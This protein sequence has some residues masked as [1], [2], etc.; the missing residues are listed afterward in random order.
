MSATHAKQKFRSIRFKLIAVAIV[1]EVVLLALVLANSSR[2]LQ[3]AMESEVGTRLHGLESRLNASLSARV[4]QHDHA[5]IAA[6]LEEL[7]RPNQ[8]DIAYIVVINNQ[9]EV[10]AKAGKVDPAHLPPLDTTVA[11]AMS[12]DIYDVDIPLTLQGQSLGRARLGISLESM[13]KTRDDLM[14]Q[15][16]VIS[17]A[18]VA[19]SLLL[20]TAGGIALTRHIPLLLAATG[21][22]ANGDYG[23]RVPIAGHDEIGRLAE[24]FNRMS[25][26]I[27]DR[28][29]ALSES[30]SRFRQIFDTINEAI[31][32]H[33]PASD[34]ILDVNQPICEM[35]G[36]A[37]TEALRISPEAISSG[38]P[39]Y[40]E[41]EFLARIR[42]AA[43]D[44]PATFVWH[45]RRKNGEQFWAE[46]SLHPARIGERELLLIVVRDIDERIRHQQELDYLTHHDRL[47]RLPNRILLADRLQQ[48][49]ARAR[50]LEKLLVVAYL[51][52]D[53]F[54]PINESLGRVSADHLLVAVAERLKACVRESDTASRFGGDEF[55]LLL[56]E[57]D[58]VG[59]CTEALGRILDTLAAPFPIGDAEIAVTA[60]MGVTIFP[61]DNAYPEILL[62]HADEAM[63]TAKRTGRNRFHLFDAEQDQLAREYRAAHERIAQGLR[64]G[65]FLLY[66]QPQVDLRLHRVVGVEALIR[67]Q[68]PERGL[69]PPGEFL[70]LIEETDLTIEL[71]NWVLEHAIAQLAAWHEAGLAIHVGVNIAARHIQAGGFVARI[72]DLLAQYPNLPPARLQLEILE[73]TAL[74]DMVKVTGVIDACHRLGIKFALD[75]FGTGYSSLSYLKQLHLDILK[76]DQSFI[77]NMLADIE[78]KVIVI[79]VIGLAQAFQC[80]VVAEGVEMDEQGQALLSMGCAIVQGYGIARPMPAEALAE[81]IAAY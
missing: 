32:I 74:G 47:T 62:R 79:G 37:R 23:W 40:T 61:L 78:D 60:S 50:R 13:V 39:P 41:A 43:I 3:N 53:N 46:V 42:R 67:W 36:H 59:E 20:L 10:L 58:T 26:I 7:I 5:E 34:A 57:L 19:I 6:T 71:G 45:C 80:Q 11:A 69:L 54:K 30:E 14:R 76:I 29:R 17:L 65:E 70:P 28:I 68:H 38:D 33:D 66:Y 21:R 22:I 77:R 55:V 75:D 24:H 44:G 72:A 9:R 18:G 27:E 63:Q 25:S 64:N 52:L 48:E 1:V 51:D 56:S 12:D 16:V 49:V 35:F 4:F 31:F 8:S 15:G 73:T 81:W 2:L